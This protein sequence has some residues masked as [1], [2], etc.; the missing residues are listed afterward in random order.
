MKLG[1][2]IG[3]FNPVHIGHISIVNYLLDNGI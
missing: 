2:Y 3:S 1:V